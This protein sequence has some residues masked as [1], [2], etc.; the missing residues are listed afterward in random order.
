MTFAEL[1]KAKREAAGLTRLELARAAGVKPPSISFYELGKSG[2][3]WV[4]LQRLA[5]ALGVSTEELR[6]LPRKHADRRPD[7]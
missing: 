6:H 7:E 1:L 3:G 2:P 5:D 4:N